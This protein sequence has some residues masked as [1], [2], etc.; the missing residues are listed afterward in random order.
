MAAAVSDKQ[1]GEMV[2]AGNVLKDFQSFGSTKE[3]IFCDI[4]ELKHYY[5]NMVEISTGAIG[6][7]S[8]IKSISAEV[9]GLNTYNLLVRNAFWGTLIE[10]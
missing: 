2:E 6:V 1:V 9:T 7:F 10:D 5:D 4:I 3:E 8:Y